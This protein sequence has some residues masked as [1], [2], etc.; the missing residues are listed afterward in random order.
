MD[1]AAG[2]AEGRGAPHGWGEGGGDFQRSEKRLFKY[3]LKT[4]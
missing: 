2:P 4:V 1:V 3:C